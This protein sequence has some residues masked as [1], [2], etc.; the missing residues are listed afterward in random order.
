MSSETSLL[1][2][3]RS[4]KRKKKHVSV[5]CLPLSNLPTS[6]TL[7]VAMM[8]VD[9]V[10]N[11]CSGECIRCHETYMITHTRSDYDL[12]KDLRMLATIFPLAHDQA[13]CTVR[14]DLW[15]VFVLTTPACSPDIA[16]RVLS[17]NS[18]LLNTMSQQMTLCSGPT[19]VTPCDPPSHESREKRPS[20]SP[21]PRR[22]KA[23]EFDA[24]EEAEY[25]AG[26][27]NTH[28]TSSLG[29]HK[30]GQGPF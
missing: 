5:I 24:N 21:P 22:P 16:W 26:R 29:S 2:L 17:S 18:A 11:A 27:F 8:C 25:M 30:L 23:T 3:Q 19:E 6:A 9:L 12:A 4:A 10:V 14:L 20:R 1:A 28:V 15:S 7:I 13:M